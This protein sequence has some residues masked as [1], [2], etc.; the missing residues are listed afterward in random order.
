M[1]HHDLGRAVGLEREPPGQK[2]EQ[3]DAHRVEIAAAVDGV[4]APLLGRHVVR[5]AAHDARARDGGRLRVGLQLR[6]PEV[7]D[8]H[9]VSAAAERLEDHVLGLQIAMHDAQVV[10]FTEGGE[11]L[12]QHVDDASEGQRPLLVRDAREVLAPQELHHEVRLPVLGPAEVEHGHRVRM[13][14]LAR[15]ARFGHEAQGRVLVRKEMGVDDFDGDGTAEGALLG[16]VDA[17]HAADAD[18]VED[19]VAAR[20][21]LADELVGGV[22]A[23]GAHRE[24]AGRAVL[25]LLVAARAAMRADPWRGLGARH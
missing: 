7:H 2:L 20:Q 22:H 24:A 13:V 19:V 12:A 23:D 5:R 18:E 8:L 15:R 10:R 11:H 3:D 4:A 1:H 6:E 14:E 25:V 16:T 9:E 21:R 17:P